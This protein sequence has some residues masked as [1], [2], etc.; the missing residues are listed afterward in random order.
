VKKIFSLLLIILIFS[1]IGGSLYGRNIPRTASLPADS[2][3]QLPSPSPQVLSSAKVSTPVLLQIPKLNIEADIESVGLDREGKMDVPKKAQNAAWYNLGV[4][5]GEKGNAVMAGHLD[6]IT[7]APAVF[8]KLG[9]LNAGDEI[10]VKDDNGNVLIYKV[11]E[12]KTYSNEDFP[13]EEV[14]GVSDRYRLN[15]ITCSGQFNSSA[16]SYSHRTV[17]Y[18]ELI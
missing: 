12:K 8:Y 16:N 7:G 13:L 17:V 1:L 18:S 6:T 2:Q 14:F 4:K 9:S 15:L 5:P 3:T 11:I 10:K